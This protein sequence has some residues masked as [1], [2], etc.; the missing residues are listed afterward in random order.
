MV[1][2]T[3]TMEAAHVHTKGLE[4]N[5]RVCGVRV[6]SKDH[7]YGAGQHCSHCKE[8]KYCST[9]DHIYA[10]GSKHC[11]IC[12]MRK[13]VQGDHTQGDAGYCTTCGVRACKKGLHS[14][15]GDYCTQCGLRC[16]HEYSKEEGCCGLCGRN[17]K[18]EHYYVN[19]HHDKPR[20]CC[21]CGINGVDDPNPKDGH[22]KRLLS[23][24]CEDIVKRARLD[25]DKFVKVYSDDSRDYLMNAAYNRFIATSAR[26]K[27]T[28]MLNYKLYGHVD[29]RALI[30]D[31]ESDWEKFAT[32]YKGYYMRSG[33]C[34]INSI[35]S[36]HNKT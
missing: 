31:M 9:A 36:A 6:C 12:G 17:C 30:G 10:D 1:T 35:A 18:D 34:I 20:I 26:I 27:G 25:A 2:F 28:F 19:P 32:D 3:L 7:E 13:C 33:H 23:Q 14:P 5:C 22:G 29:D 11:Y 8:I 24:P 4:G 15:W 21:H 16:S